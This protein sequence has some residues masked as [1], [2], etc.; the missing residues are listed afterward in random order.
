M[1]ADYFPVIRLARVEDILE[2][3]SIDL[4]KAGTQDF[5][6]L[7]QRCIGP[8]ASGFRW[9]F[10]GKLV[11]D[12]ASVR[13]L[14]PMVFVRSMKTAIMPLLVADAEALAYWGVYPEKRTVH[15]MAIAL[16]KAY[17]G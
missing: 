1:R 17:L 3:F 15:Y 14:W 11:N 2:A 4:S 13:G 12:M 9:P 6:E 7:V 16:A 5:L 8:V 10:V